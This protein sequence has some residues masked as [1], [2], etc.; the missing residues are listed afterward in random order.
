MEQGLA[1]ILIADDER[2]IS[3]FLQKSLEEEDSRYQVEICHSGAEALVKVIR[4]PFDLI[5]ADLR[6]PDL[7]GLRLLKQA[8]RLNSSTKAILMTAYG[9]D[10]AEAEAKHLG[11][12]YIAKPF[13]MEDMKRLVRRV[14]GLN[15]KGGRNDVNGR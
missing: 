11:A 1:R 9:S 13:A 8:M 2:T 14:C 5:I 15:N 3:F 7:D 12:E 4:T 10:G 6:M